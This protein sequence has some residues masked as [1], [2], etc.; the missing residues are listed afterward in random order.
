MSCVDNGAVR[1]T[2]AVTVLFAFAFVASGQQQKVLVRD[3][4]EES[5]LQNEISALKKNSRTTLSADVSQLTKQVNE[6]AIDG[7]PWSAEARTTLKLKG[8]IRDTLR[9]IEGGL[10]AR[11]IRIRR[12]EQRQMRISRN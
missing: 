6:R 7:A 3:I 4:T 10:V 2:A 1:V 12:F 5:S 8:E 9:V 11:M